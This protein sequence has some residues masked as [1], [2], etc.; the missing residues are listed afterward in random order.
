MTDSVSELRVSDRQAVITFWFA[1][2][3]HRY[4]FRK[5]DRFDGTVRR[6]FRGVYDEVVAG[7][8]PDWM[9]MPEGCLATIL[10]LDQFPRNMF[11]GTPQAF[12]T[13]AQARAVARLALQKT[14]D[15]PLALE[16]RLF[17]YMP[18]EHSES[19]DDQELSCQLMTRLGDPGYL[20][21]AE[22]HREIIRRFG[23][24]PHRNRILG[25]D[26]TPA[27]AAYLAQPGSGF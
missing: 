24:F 11:R 1:E 13:D 16:Q 17:M 8:N 12:A 25:R 6:R 20:Y 5:D 15:R 19:M 26:N 14:F 7:R 18:F 9:A 27:E 10:V 21:Y 2:I 4:W 23:R 3:D 22:R